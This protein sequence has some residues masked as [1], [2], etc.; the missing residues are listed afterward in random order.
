VSLSRRGESPSINR[1]H[2]VEFVSVVGR[3]HRCNEYNSNRRGGAGIFSV[4]GRP[5]TP[6]RRGANGSRQAV[7][8]CLLYVPELPSTLSTHQIRSWTRDRRSADN[9][10]A[11]WR[12][13]PWPRRRFSFRSTFSCARQRALGRERAEGHNEDVRRTHTRLGLLGLLA[14]IFLGPLVAGSDW[15]LWARLLALRS[16]SVGRCE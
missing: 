5:E 16:A 15:R 11:L 13:V 2:L 14:G 3:P 8:I 1:R 7:Y 12:T 4:S 9:V 10:R 6:G